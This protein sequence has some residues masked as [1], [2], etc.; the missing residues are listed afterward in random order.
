[1]TLPATEL[2]HLAP[3]RPRIAARAVGAALA[4]VL[5]LPI[6]DD[7]LEEQVRKSMVRMIAARHSV[8]ITRGAVWNLSVEHDTPTWRRLSTAAAVG[9]FLWRALRKTLVVLA[10][11]R[12]ADEAAR[13][14]QLGT[15][16]DHYFGKLHGGGELDAAHA[17]KLHK[18][19]V[20]AMNQT[21]RESLTRTFQQGIMSAARTTATMPL[22]MVV[23]FAR[24][25]VWSPDEV[26]DAKVAE[27]T[28]EAAPE[29]F[30]AKASRNVSED[31]ATS[32]SEY[33]AG[34]VELF[35]LLWRESAADPA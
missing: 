20:M 30:V 31:I 23:N 32:G 7:I 17:R 8:K 12:Q 10:V 13:T 2:A 19:I 5:P 6:I 18:V 28:D 27:V 14:F 29:S 1:V 25:V 16:L 33:L 9:S 22:Q 34:L 35:T 24:A 21:R 26:A 11:A 3:L 15:L 4:G